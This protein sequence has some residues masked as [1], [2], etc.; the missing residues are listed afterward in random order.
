MY[1]VP[2]ELK[3]PAQINNFRTITSVYIKYLHQ[4]I[5][6]YFNKIFIL[7]DFLLFLSTTLYIL[8]LSISLP[9][10]S[11]WLLS[12]SLCTH[13][14]MSASLLKQDPI[15]KQALISSK[16][17]THS[18]NKTQSPLPLGQAPIKQDSQAPISTDQTR[19]TSTDRSSQAPIYLSVGLSVWVCLCASNDSYMMWYFRSHQGITSYMNHKLVVWC[20]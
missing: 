14:S 13:L 6:R 16:T 2:C 3:W 11:D 1:H 9:I 10:F 20:S 19:P 12:L 8:S 4:F 15:S 18:S 7:F 17:H 5:I